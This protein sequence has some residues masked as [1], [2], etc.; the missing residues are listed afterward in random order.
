MLSAAKHPPGII[1][2]VPGPD[3][4]VRIGVLGAARIVPMALIE[5]A[6]RSDEVVVVSVAARHV[7]RAQ[8]FVAKHGIARVHG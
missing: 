3:S 6:K 8:A 2:D 1:G 7:T 5:P 4:P